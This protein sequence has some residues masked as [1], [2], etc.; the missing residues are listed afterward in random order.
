[1]WFQEDPFQHECRIQ[2][3]RSSELRVPIKAKTD[4][5]N[6]MS[7][8]LDCGLWRTIII[9]TILGQDPGRG[10]P[11]L[12]AILESIDHIGLFNFVC[13]SGSY[14]GST[15]RRRRR[16]HCA[17]M[18]RNG[19]GRFLV[20]Q[21]QKHVADLAHTKTTET[22]GGKCGHVPFVDQVA[23][24]KVGCHD[25]CCQMQDAPTVKGNL[26]AVK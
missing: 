15:R 22:V 26:H 25:Q 2:C 10:L 24:R 6:T 9:I 8:T 11:P 1:M 20:Q 19:G 14:W 13:F 16:R 12:S 18:R 4:F 17:I 7:S 5:V 21:P 23:A 3:I